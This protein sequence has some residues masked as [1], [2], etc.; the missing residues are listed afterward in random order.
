M[1]EFLLV[2]NEKTGWTFG[3][4]AMFAASVSLF[5]TFS[6]KTV[7]AGWK[8]VL[9]WAAA[10]IVIG[11]IWA[12]VRWF[13]HAARRRAFF[14]EMKQK[15]VSVHTDTCPFLATSRF[16]DWEEPYK[17]EFLEF[18]VRAWNAA[19]PKMTRDYGTMA[20]VRSAGADTMAKQVFADLVPKAKRE[21]SRITLWLAF[22]PFS[23][24]CYMMEDL[25]RDFY[26]WLVRVV[27]GIMHGINRIVFSGVKKE[28]G[29]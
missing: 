12:L 24:L 6:P 27:S 7:I 2:L 5:T 15:W 29:A 16:A 14:Y 23:V 13:L 9:L 8:G 26:R 22:W 20:C 10:Y 17:M 1:I 21:K 4:A 18:F 28:L 19:D 25:L 11:V 3:V